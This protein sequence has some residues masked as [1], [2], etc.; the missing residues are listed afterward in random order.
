[1]NITLFADMLGSKELLD[2]LLF[3]YT[4]FNFKLK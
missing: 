1:L 3:I 4:Y 2:I